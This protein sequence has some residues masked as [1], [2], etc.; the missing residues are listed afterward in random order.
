[1]PSYLSS[2]HVIACPVDERMAANQMSTLLASNQDV[3]PR[4]SDA[5][6]LHVSKFAG[7]V[8][9]VALNMVDLATTRLALAHG[10]HE[11]NPITRTFLAHGWW[12]LFLIKFVVPVGI[13]FRATRPARK[14]PVLE[15]RAMWAVASLYVVVVTSNLVLTWARW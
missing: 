6:A 7:A 8:A 5:H 4:I 12:A 2:R 10:L 14:N 13:M 3:L 15:A 1:M 9:V 11:G